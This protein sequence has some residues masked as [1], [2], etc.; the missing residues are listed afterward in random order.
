MKSLF[1]LKRLCYM[2]VSKFFYIL[3]FILGFI[4]GLLNKNIIELIKG[5]IQ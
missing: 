1:K 3:F 5:V 2:F 4:C